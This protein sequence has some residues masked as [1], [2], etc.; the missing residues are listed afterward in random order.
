[1]LSVVLVHRPLCPLH[2]QPPYPYLCL[3][4][5]LEL[6][7]VSS[8]TALS[9]HQ[10]WPWTTTRTRTTTFPR[11]G[12]RRLSAAVWLLVHRPLR[13][14]RPLHLQPPYLCLL[15]RLELALVSLSLYLRP[16]VLP[17]ML[18]VC[19]DACLCVQLVLLN[20]SSILGTTALS[21][22]QGWP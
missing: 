14:R 1:M 17:L 13:P 4:P 12:R 7:S 9:H 11:R 3:L 21:H 19:P 18:G 2:L 22:H 5:R 20:Q 10:R 6:A 8:T 16:L 15:P